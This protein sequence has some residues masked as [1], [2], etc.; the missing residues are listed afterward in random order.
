MSSDATGASW[1][2]LLVLTAL[3][4]NARYSRGH[5]T[6][7][8]TAAPTAGAQAIAAG[9]AHIYTVAAAAPA[10]AAANRNAHLPRLSTD[11]LWYSR[12]L[13]TLAPGRGSSATP[14]P[15]AEGLLLR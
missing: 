8:P 9:P 2:C 15:A 5:A 10:A 7:K 3:S 1:D 6:A 11:P 4:L 14:M 13:Y 12:T